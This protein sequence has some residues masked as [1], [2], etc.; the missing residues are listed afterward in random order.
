VPLLEI[1]MQP[2]TTFYA[3]RSTAVSAKLLCRRAGHGT[4]VSKLVLAAHRHERGKGWLELRLR[5]SPQKAAQ[6]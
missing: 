4:K 5:H 3:S 1:R 2:F 6:P